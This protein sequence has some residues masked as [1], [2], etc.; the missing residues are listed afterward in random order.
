M[1]ESLRRQA[2]DAAQEALHVANEFYYRNGRRN[3]YMDASY[4][5][6]E[7][8]LDLIDAE[9]ERIQKADPGAPD[10]FRIFGSEAE[11]VDWFGR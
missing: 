1:L 6:A 2:N 11:A 10:Y 5:A 4:V 9:I 8:L 7:R 3:S